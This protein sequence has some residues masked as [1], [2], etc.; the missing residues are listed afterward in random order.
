VR[1]EARPRGARKQELHGDK[2]HARGVPEGAAHGAE[3]Q[4]GSHV[5][6]QRVQREHRRGR[7][8][9]GDEDVVAVQDAQRVH[10]LEEAER[11][12]LEQARRGKARVEHDDAVAEVRVLQAADEQ[13]GA[14]GRP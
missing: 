14:R 9:H 11:V 12:E 7:G 2:V 6:V 3:F 13:R 4:R 1:A 5:R 10:G 8:L